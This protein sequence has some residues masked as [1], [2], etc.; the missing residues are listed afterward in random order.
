V[1]EGRHLLFRSFIT[2]SGLG[3][4]ARFAGGEVR[5]CITVAITPTPHGI[6]RWGGPGA[7][8]SASRRLRRY[9]G[10][11]LRL[12]GVTKARELGHVH[13]G[14]ASDAPSGLPC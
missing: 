7:I 2:G 3:F 1:L 13:L 8:A 10:L 5:G 4:T 6:F 11:S 9:V 12:S 14:F